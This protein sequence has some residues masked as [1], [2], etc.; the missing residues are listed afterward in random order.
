LKNKKCV[1]KCSK[2]NLKDIKKNFA[3][4]WEFESIKGL[5]LKISIHKNDIYIFAE[6]KFSFWKSTMINLT[7]KYVPDLR[8]RHPCC[9][10]IT[11]TTGAGKSHFVKNLIE[12]GGTDVVY[13]KIYYY[14]PKIE[15]LGIL[16]GANQ[17]MFIDKGLPKQ[18]WVDAHIKKDGTK[19]LIVIDDQWQRS[20]ECPVVYDLITHDRRHLQVSLIFISQNFFEKSKSNHAVTY[21][22]ATKICMK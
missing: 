2:F 8:F 6:L 13:D 21:R 19:N 11:G 12:C 18:D 10:L 20:L 9:L 7:T 5:A 3:T 15:E 17:Q 14:M 4:W 22:Y 1:S 16:P